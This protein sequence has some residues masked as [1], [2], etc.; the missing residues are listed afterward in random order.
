MATFKICTKNIRADKTY[1]VKIRITH[2]RKTLYISSPYYISE[3]EVT[4]GGKIKNLD[5]VYSCEEIIK[6]YRNKLIS[7]HNIEYMETSEIVEKLLSSPKIDYIDFLEFGKKHI[8]KLKTDNRLGNARVYSVAI[9]S[10]EKF[11]GKNSL[12]INL[13]TTAFINKYIDWLNS[14]VSQ[15][16]KLKQTKNSAR[17]NIYL[18]K[19]KT[20][21]NLAKDTYNDE[22]IGDIRVRTSPFK[23]ITIPDLP[24]TEHRALTLLQIKEIFNLQCPDTLTRTKQKMFEY[25]KDMFQLSFCLCG[26]NAIDLYNCTD[27][28]DGRITYKRTKT[29]NKRRDDAL[30]SINVEPE[31]EEIFNRY[32]DVTGERVFKF[33]KMYVPCSFNQA[34]AAA[35]NRINEALGYDTLN[36]YSARHSWATIAYNDAEVDKYDVHLALNHV[37]SSMAITD[38]YIKKDW[39]KI[40]RANRKVLDLVYHNIKQKK[41]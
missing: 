14:P 33:H 3:K 27:Y 6:T 13:I 16:L 29:K 22:D 10:F 21:H 34:I 12:D 31:I 17:V 24:K 26:M 19:L 20:I 37:D 8:A 28:S 1:N 4:K 9:N 11:I 15:T 7:F 36:F 32:R 40:D 18:S 23:K 30:I 39:S 35:T 38:V 41:Q 5:V 2:N 25:G